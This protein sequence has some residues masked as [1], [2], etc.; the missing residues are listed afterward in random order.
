MAGSTPALDA[1]TAG[2]SIA[3]NAFQSS[4]NR[5]VD[6]ANLNLQQQ[7]AY[8]KAQIERAQLQLDQQKA[9]RLAQ[10]DA[11]RKALTAALGGNV[12]DVNYTA[13]EGFSGGLRP[14]AIG[15]AGKE[16][17]AFLSAQ[18]MKSLTNP[19]ARPELAP[20]QRFKIGDQQA[21][22]DPTVGKKPG[23]W[24]KTGYLLSGQLAKLANSTDK[25]YRKPGSHTPLSQ[26]G[27]LDPVSATQ[28]LVNNRVVSAP[29]Y[30]WS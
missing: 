20:Y 18:A 24:A 17:A 6:Q 4:Q 27:P 5:K 15:A 16:A 26:P 13:G 14:S 7:Q 8:E 9:E 11:Y 29:G 3:N 28:P 22:E 19:E 25:D 30:R 1:I 10:S 2:A 23:F 21:Y 12:Q